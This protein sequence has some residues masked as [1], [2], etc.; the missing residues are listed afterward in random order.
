MGGPLSVKPKSPFVGQRVYR[1]LSWGS[2]VCLTA[3][4]F[5]PFPVACSVSSSFPVG[6]SREDTGCKWTRRPPRV[7][8]A[9]EVQVLSINWKRHQTGGSEV[10]GADDG[11]V[12]ARVPAGP[13]RPCNEAGTKRSHSSRTAPSSWGRKQQLPGLGGVA[14]A[15]GY[16]SSLGAGSCGAGD[17]HPEHGPHSQR[18][19]P[20]TP[21]RLRC[22]FGR[23]KVPNCG[24]H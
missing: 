23:E 7:S 17:L 18:S 8:G 14:V 5:P 16:G 2:W 15:D 1:R 12:P 20:P 6:F 21:C 9:R 22:F 19:H 13:W 4:G 3:W 24:P 10:L 11:A